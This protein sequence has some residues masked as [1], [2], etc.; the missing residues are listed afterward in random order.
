M[1]LQDIITSDDPIFKG[2]FSPWASFAR[3]AVN[4]ET[5]PEEL[6][7]FLAEPR[8]EMGNMQ[9]PVFDERTSQ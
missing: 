6:R 2:N 7:K 3:E 5:L 1:S 4:D 8:Q 9:V